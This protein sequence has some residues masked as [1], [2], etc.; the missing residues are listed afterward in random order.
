MSL[1]QFLYRNQD[2]KDYKRRT[3][4]LNESRGRNVVQM[5]R[6]EI[7]SNE[8]VNR[9]QIILYWETCTSIQRTKELYHNRIT[10]SKRANKTIMRKTMQYPLPFSSESRRNLR[11]R[12]IAPCNLISV[13]STFRSKSSK[14]LALIS[15]Y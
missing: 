9:K 3:Q 1:Q 13:R 11:M 6:P 7:S 5:D 14:S 15:H 8:F 12:C 4:R 2:V 10:A